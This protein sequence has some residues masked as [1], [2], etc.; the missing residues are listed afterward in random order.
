MKYQKI[1]IL[2][3][4]A[5]DFQFMTRKWNIANNNLNANFDVGNYIVYNAGVLKPKLCDYNDTYILVRGNITM[6][7]NI[8]TRVAFKNCVPFTNCIT[9]INVTKIDDAEDLDLVISIHNLLEYKPNIFDT[10]WSLWFY[11]QDQ[12]INFNNAIAD[13][14]YL[15]FHVERENSR[16]NRK[17][18]ARK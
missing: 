5:S 2:L 15:V 16:M 12:V 14:N 17:Q 11:S 13:N 9:K 3:N 4:E 10:R 1:L 7:R 6:A 18:N 8:A